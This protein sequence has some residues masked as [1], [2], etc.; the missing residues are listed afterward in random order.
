MFELIRADLKRKRQSYGVRPEDQT[1]FRQWVTPFLEFGT[2]TVI[3]YRFGRWAYSVK[4]PILR[5]ILI[6]IYLF[7]DAF[8]VAITG[9]KVHPESDIGPGLVIHTFSCVHVLVKRMGHSCTINSGVS[10]ANIRGSGRPTIGNNCYFG[11]GCKVMGGVTI[12]D[13]VVVAANSLVISDVPTGSTVMG[14]PAR[15]ISRE[16]SSPYLKTPVAPVPVESTI[17]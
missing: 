10:L 2:F 12:G 14:V 16:I 6:A 1:F 8:C 3:D 11:A 4:V 9:M 17:A 7:V 15:I 13:N 5:Q